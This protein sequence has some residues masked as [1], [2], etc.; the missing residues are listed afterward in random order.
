[1][2]NCGVLL[3]KKG[4]GIVARE[5]R[6]CGTCGS[7]II[8]NR[9]NLSN[10][11]FY[12]GYHHHIGCLVEKA[13]KG[14]ESG[15]RVANWEKIL[16]RI[17]EFQEE[18]RRRLEHCAIQD[19]FNDYLLAHYDVEVVSN[20]FWNIIG[21]LGLGKY[22]RNK[23]KPI[24]MDTIFQTWKWGQKHLDRIAANNKARHK[25]PNN[26][27]QRLN[28]DLAIVVQHVGDYK[29]HI[30]ATKEQAETVAKHAENKNKINYEQLYSQSSNQQQ[31]D[32]IIDLMNDIF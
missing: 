26:D 22:K 18:S 21:D 16:N 14:I 24:D 5:T 9:Q 13:N 32:S 6:K 12:Q 20:W 2:G 28:Y 8:V 15:K 27:E 11:V 10:I 3:T 17:P 19:E 31:T 23:C 30:T 29:K 7:P 1:M 4:G 25:G